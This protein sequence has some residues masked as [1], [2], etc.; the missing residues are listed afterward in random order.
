M[1]RTQREPPGRGQR[2]AIRALPS[3]SRGGAPPEGP[4]HQTARGAQLKQQGA[5]RK[6]QCRT[7]AGQHR[8]SLNCQTAPGLRNAGR[9]ANLA[10]GRRQVSPRRGKSAASHMST[11]PRTRS[12]K[13]EEQHWLGE[14]EQHLLGDK[15]ASRRGGSSTSPPAGDS[16]SPRGRQQYKFE[17]AQGGS[18]TVRVPRPGTARVCADGRRGPGSATPRSTQIAGSCKSSQ[19][20]VRG[21]GQCAR[22]WCGEKE[23]K[24]SSAK[25]PQRAPRS[26]CR[27]APARASRG[28]GG[29]KE[30]SPATSGSLFFSTGSFFFS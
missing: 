29:G 2:E 12:A 14:S 6:G 13:S 19:T 18:A 30:T 27:S 15:A 25:Q 22:L 4:R 1:Q 11:R 26:D 3:R 9:S 21:R 7:T 17:A 5:H 20:T 8:C 10:E 24:S 16:A 23:A 28:R